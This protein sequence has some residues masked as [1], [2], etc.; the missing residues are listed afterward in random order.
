[1]GVVEAAPAA[2]FVAAGSLAIVALGAVLF[3]RAVTL[4]LVL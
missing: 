3:Y 2:A 4:W 1:V